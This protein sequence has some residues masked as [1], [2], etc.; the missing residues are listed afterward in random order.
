MIVGLWYLYNT[1]L[2][3][4]KQISDYQYISIY[5]P[6]VTTYGFVSKSVSGHQRYR[7]IAETDIQMEEIDRAVVSVLSVHLTLKEEPS[8]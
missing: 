1:G 8:Y 4:C 2:I 6:W 7:I 3:Q 5:S